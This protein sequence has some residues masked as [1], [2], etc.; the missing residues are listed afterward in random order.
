MTPPLVIP[1]FG[2]FFCASPAT[3]S[4][5]AKAAQAATAIRGRE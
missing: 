4:S 2:A 5:T 1:C 3:G